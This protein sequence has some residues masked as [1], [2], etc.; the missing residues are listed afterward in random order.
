MKKLFALLLAMMMVLSLAD[1]RNNLSLSYKVAIP[2]AF[3]FSLV[4]IIWG[5]SFAWIIPTLIAMALGVA[6]DKKR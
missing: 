3:V 4:G 1:G 5:N 6:A 2:V